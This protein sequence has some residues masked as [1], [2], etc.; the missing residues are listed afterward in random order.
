MAENDAVW[1]F[2]RAPV[3]MRIHGLIRRALNPHQS[4]V[5]G[6]ERAYLEALQKAVAEIAKA[7]RNSDR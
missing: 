4:G 3:Q 7:I 5:D 1:W 6:D 2:Y